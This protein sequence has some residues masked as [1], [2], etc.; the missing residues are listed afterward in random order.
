MG[1]SNKSSPNTRSGMG[2]IR[3]IFIVDECASDA[4]A[5]KQPA[6]IDDHFIHPRGRV[7]PDVQPGTGITIQTVV[8][9]DS[10]YWSLLA[11]SVDFS[12]R[13]IDETDVAAFNAA[14][15]EKRQKRTM[16]GYDIAK[17]V[18]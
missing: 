10:V 1:A 13:S 17:R 16:T 4:L 15:C 18:A 9:A 14:R 5:C 8:G 2:L 3:T 6:K 7:A 12:A 11:V